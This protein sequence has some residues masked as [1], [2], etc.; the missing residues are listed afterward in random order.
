MNF[1]LSS[2]MKLAIGSAVFAAGALL[3]VTL[4]NYQLQV[5]TSLAMLCVLCWA[6]N[7]VGGYMGYPSLATSA[8]FGIGAYANAVAQLHGASLSVAWMVAGLAGG[9]IAAVVGLPMLRLKGH[10]FAVGSIAMVE[11]GREIANNWDGLTGGAVGLNL[12]LMAGSP[13][14]V[15]RFFYLAMLALAFLSFALTLFIER[16][17]FGFGLRCI[18]Q[19][20][21]AASMVGMDVFRYK[22]AAFVLSGVLCAMAGSIYASMVAFIEP[23]DAF[24]IITTIEIPV[25][26]M[27]GG[28]G[29][30]FGP[31][32][33]GVFY[34]VLKEFVWANFINWHSGILGA[35]IVAVIYFIPAG[36]FGTKWS[37]LISRLRRSPERKQPKLAEI[38][39]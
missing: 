32:I 35:I 1:D 36:V 37:I 28:M 38:K 23:K 11:V 15:S 8:F 17:R 12:P 18:R 33:G 2:A 31:M 39:G 24:N 29:T 3:A 22:V 27:L 21:D 16:T 25:M 9:V 19:N 26:V 30:L 5:G 10:Y 7:F 20:E 34:V 13:D 4:D 6:W 14:Y